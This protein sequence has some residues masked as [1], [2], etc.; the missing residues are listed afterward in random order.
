MKRDKKADALAI[1]ARLAEKEKRFADSAF[2]APVIGDGR[3]RVR[4]EGVVCRLTVRD[5]FRGWAVLK[6]TGPGEA[7]VL[8]EASPALVGKY[9]RLFPRVRMILL[10]M[11]D[12]R[13]WALAA[14]TSDTRLQ[15]SGPVPIDLVGSAAR[16]QCVHVRFDGNF[17]WY[18]GVDRRRDPS[19]A[20]SLAKSLE[21]KIAPAELRCRNA[22]PQEKLAYKM[23]W[24][25]AYGEIPSRP[26]TDRERIAQALQHAGGT[27]DSF[28]YRNQEEAAVRMVVD[29]QEHLI[30]VKADDLSIVSA[31]ICLSGQ[32]GSFDL[33]SL[34]GVLRQSDQLGCY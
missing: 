26:A 24:M 9:L 14:S 21:E 32:D 12:N 23:L 13:W 34:V 17:F 20:R 22:V 15:L 28:W 7:V 16:F 5:S 18:E 31:G 10:E 4:I 27:L 8:E 30:T 2:L 19:I 25:A 3:V 1:V 6:M 33:A 29:G 11:F